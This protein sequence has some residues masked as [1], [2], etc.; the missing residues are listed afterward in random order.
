MAT[1]IDIYTENIKPLSVG[2]K[3]TIVRLIMD[4]VIPV[5]GEAV[6]PGTF[7]N[8]RQFLPDIERITFTDQELAGVTLTAS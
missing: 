2:E 7:D 3:L 1:A 6:P 8:L 5:P 4:E